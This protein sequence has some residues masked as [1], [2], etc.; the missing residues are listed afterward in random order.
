MKLRILAAAACLVLLAAPG[1][2][3]AASAQASDEARADK[4]FVATVL[5][6]TGGSMTLKKES[7]EVLFLSYDEPGLTVKID[8]GV[9][10]GSK[11]KVSVEATSMSRTLI[12]QLLPAS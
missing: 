11:V 7:G 12:V 3:F 10:K 8:K 1:L 2:V 6:I 9:E 4:S 5:E